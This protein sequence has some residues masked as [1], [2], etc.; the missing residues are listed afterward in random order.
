MTNIQIVKPVERV[1]DV[2]NKVNPKSFDGLVAAIK[3][4]DN[5]ALMGKGIDR[6]DILG[7]LQRDV[8]HVSDKKGGKVFPTFSL[9]NF[10]VSFQYQLMPR[11]RRPN[12]FQQVH[13]APYVTKIK[14]LDRNFKLRSYSEGPPDVVFYGYLP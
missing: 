9:K 3:S 12:I 2:A 10:F 4:R 13:V 7:G 6:L 5:N 11:P 14:P 1:G 8:K